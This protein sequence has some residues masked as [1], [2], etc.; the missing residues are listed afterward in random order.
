M[1]PPSWSVPGHT[2]HITYWR[3]THFC[4]LSISDG[5]MPCVRQPAVCTAA[6]LQWDTSVQRHPVYT[7]HTSCTT[8]RNSDQ[9]TQ[10]E[11]LICVFAPTCILSDSIWPPPA[12]ASH[13]SGGRAGRQETLQTL[14]PSITLKM[15]YGLHVNFIM[16]TKGHYVLRIRK[17][18]KIS[19]FLFI[20]STFLGCIHTQFCPFWLLISV[21]SNLLTSLWTDYWSGSRGHLSGS[22]VNDQ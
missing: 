12:R 16:K 13:F 22:N 8:I 18:P 4:S 3:N 10:P 6:T 1:L 15:F 2:S 20:L 17:K 11:C 21:I 5:S 14:K 7:T 9:H 19:Q